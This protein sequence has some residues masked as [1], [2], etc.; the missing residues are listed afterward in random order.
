MV[1]GTVRKDTMG[2]VLC[3]K[4]SFYKLCFILIYLLSLCI[5]LIA[6]HPSHPTSPQLL[7]SKEWEDHG[8]LEEVGCN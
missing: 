1:G 4:W 7:F 5:P 2:L 8:L 6:P 3:S